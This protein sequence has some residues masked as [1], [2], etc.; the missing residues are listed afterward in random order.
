[1]MSFDDWILCALCV[2]AVFACLLF[3]RQAYIEA[4]RID[5]ELAQQVEDWNYFL[6]TGDD[7]GYKRRMKK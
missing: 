1:M 2:A 6:Q 3:I 4:Q 5:D 7:A